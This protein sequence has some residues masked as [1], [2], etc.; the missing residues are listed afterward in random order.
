MSEASIHT[1]LANFRGGGARPNRYKVIL[2][3]PPGISGALVASTK[4]GF[5]AKAASIPASSMGVIDVAYMGRQVKIAGDKVWEDWNVTCYVD[6]DWVTRGVFEEW[7]NKILGFDTNVASEGYQDPANYFARAKVQCL[8]RYDRV[9]RTYDVEGMWPS[10]VGEVTLG[11]DQN[12]QVMEQQVTFAI[13][14]WSSES[15]R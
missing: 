13:N 5:T 1:F 2:T 7:H 4:A 8:D 11:Y 14:G 15:T 10:N 6:Q 3:F 9:T 12:D